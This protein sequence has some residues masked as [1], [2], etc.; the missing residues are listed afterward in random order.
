MLLP[1][2][3][4][5][6]FAILLGC[7]ASI[8][9]AGGE[10][11]PIASA[12]GASAGSGGA[13]AGSG[14]GAADSDP[15]P[16]ISEEARAALQAL[17]PATLPA[18][19]ADASNRF[20]DDA[21]A[22]TFGRKLFFDA[23]LSGRLLD[24]DNDGSVFALGKKGETGKV[25][26]AGCHLP[27]SVFSDTRTVEKQTSLGS[28]WGLR[29]APS[30]LD[31]GQSKVLM[32]GG[33]HDTLYNQVFGPFESEVEMNSSRLFVAQRV[34]AAHKAE[35]EA[36]FG[37]LPPLDDTKRFA[38]LSAATTG[39]DKLNSANKCEGIKRGGPGD[40]AEFDALS[41]A[42]QDA[43]TRVVVNLGKAIGA[44][45]RL[46]SCGP[47]RFDAWMAGDKKAL[48]RA[49]Q[50]GAA[51]FVGKGRCNDCH[52]GPYFSDEQFHNVGLKPATVATVFIDLDDRGAGLD[53]TLALADP[54]NIQGSFSDGDD[55]RLPPKIGPELEG[56][57]RT[58][59]LRCVAGRPSYMHTGQYRVLE[60]VVSFFSRGGEA[61]GYPGKNELKALALSPLERADLA[62]FLRALD[63][64][65]PSKEL[66]GPP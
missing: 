28:G 18:P 45:E 47:G 61:F 40:A 5:R 54:L 62:A 33:R 38:A 14:V 9:C 43:V 6:F 31:V 52:S 32:W 37:A 10:R 42:D 23:S 51:L 63:G 41:A 57:F 48:S 1:V 64:P 58:P 49:E 34:F 59:R 39:C 24:G 30:L 66:L 3:P 21:A 2:G 65:G 16:V 35:Y 53:L 22:A 4:A 27:E 50:R 29:R 36:I 12:G 19:P 46:L 13:A 15:D 55:G 26:C 60:D 25:A 11:Q 8:S 44:Y 56:A 7:V 20:A 17:S